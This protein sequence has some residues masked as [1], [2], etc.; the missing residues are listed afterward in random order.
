MMIETRHAFR[1][2][3]RLV[4][5][6]ATFVLAGCVA[7]TSGDASTSTHTD[8]RPGSTVTTEVPRY[9]IDPGLDFLIGKAKE[10]L[11]G[12]LNVDVG[13]I[14][15]YNAYLVVWPDSSLGCPDPEKAYVPVIADGSV[16]ELRVAEVLYRYHTGGDV[17][18]PF[19]CEHPSHDEQVVN[20]TPL[21]TA[22]SHESDD[23]VPPPGYED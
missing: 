9:P 20:D 15:V 3:P 8:T 21:D 16:I 19:L 1:R 14:D 5:L 23:T 13:E 6:A 18:R 7:G 11:A 22:G 17:A 4:V 12:R 2:L 10:D